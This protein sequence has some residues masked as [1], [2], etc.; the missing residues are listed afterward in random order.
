MLVIRKNL[1]MCLFCSIFAVIIIGWS[2]SA[3]ADLVP[4]LRGTWN[5]SGT[6]TAAN[7]S[8]PD[9]NGVSMGNGSLV[10]NSQTGANF[11]GTVT[12]AAA[13]GGLCGNHRLLRDSGSGWF[14]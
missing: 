13:G 3:W 12:I 2:S 8:D 14:V 6:E 7:C 9:D 10:I 4:D 1:S 5:G 11:S